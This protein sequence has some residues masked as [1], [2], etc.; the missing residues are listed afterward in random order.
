MCVVTVRD[1]VSGR[2]YRRPTES[3]VRAATFAARALARRVPKQANGF[4][5]V[6][7]GKLNHLRGFFNIV[8][9]GMTTWGDLFSPRQ[10]LILTTLNECV[11]KAGERIAKESEKGFADA[12][13]TCLGL[14]VS[15]HADI[16]ASLG[17]WHNTRELITHVFG[18]QALPMVWDFA[19]ANPFSE[20]SGAFLGGVD[21]ISRVLE[22]PISPSGML[23]KL[24]QQSIR[25]QKMLRT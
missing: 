10:K 19:E 6:P 15:R 22:Q 23:N 11:H 12:V 20:A 4:S 18:R 13:Q 7:D 21:W 14:A 5:Q 9:Y 17:M 2:T 25:C 3:D 16:N 8:L 24:P 1:D